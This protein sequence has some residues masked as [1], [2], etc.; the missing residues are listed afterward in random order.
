MA[1]LPRSGSW[2]P[3]T[4]THHHTADRR[5]PD[6]PTAA[7]RATAIVEAPTPG[8]TS[9]ARAAGGLPASVASSVIDRL[10]EL[11][12]SARQPAA[13]ASFLRAATFGPR[14]GRLAASKRRP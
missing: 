3:R 9:V 7:Y 11:S 1:G 13:P 6:A 14:C 2:C 8:T 4:P 12:A 10:A 5:Y